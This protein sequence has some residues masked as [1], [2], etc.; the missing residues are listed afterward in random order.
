[1]STPEPRGPLAEGGIETRMSPRRSALLV[2]C[3]ALGAWT[4]LFVILHYAAGFDLTL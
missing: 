3:V 4:A 2:A 1:M